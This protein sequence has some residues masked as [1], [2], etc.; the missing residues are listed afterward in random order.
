MTKCMNKHTCYL[1]QSNLYCD[2]NNFILFPSPYYHILRRRQDWRKSLKK[3]WYLKLKK[4]GSR[5]S[6][7]VWETM[8]K[9]WWYIIP[10]V[11]VIFLFPLVNVNKL[12][13]WWWCTNSIERNY[14][15]NFFK[16]AYV[17]SIYIYFCFNFLELYI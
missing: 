10:I 9:N 3:S 8:R 5:D 7:S 17:I 16:M 2:S 1:L 13:F 15:K 6:V 12:C 14:F 4:F 11:L